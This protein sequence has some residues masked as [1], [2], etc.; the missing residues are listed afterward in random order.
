[1]TFLLKNILLKWQ[2]K[3]IQSLL[4]LIA[5]IFQFHVK[6][7]EMRPEESPG[8]I[9]VINVADSMVTDTLTHLKKWDSNDYYVSGSVTWKN[10]DGHKNVNFDLRFGINLE[11]RLNEVDLRADARYVSKKDAPNDNEQN[12][13]INWYRKLYGNIYAAGQGRIER[14]QKIIESVRLDYAILI[15]GIGPGYLFETKKGDRSR[16]SIL[17]YYIQFFIFKESDEIHDFSPSIYL[18]NNYQL[19]KKL[20]LKN[21]TNVIFY[22]KSDIGYEM[23]TELGYAITKNLSLGFRHYYLF[24]GPT[25]Q[26]NNSNELKIFTKITF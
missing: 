10:D 16:L 9:P 15:G 14:N 26:K 19:S 24:N 2:P 6:A 13:R 1:M 18:D 25:L 5:L 7:I 17:Y 8:E 22:A 12:F 11:N 20:N 21:W 23:E 4:I 3:K